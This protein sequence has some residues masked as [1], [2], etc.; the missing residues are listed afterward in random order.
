MKERVLNLMSYAV[1]YGAVNKDSDAE[2]FARDV[3]NICYGLLHEMG[4][5]ESDFDNYFAKVKESM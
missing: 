5:S 3:F 1:L 4:G 2:A